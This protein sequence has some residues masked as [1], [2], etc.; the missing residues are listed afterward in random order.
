MFWG[1]LSLSLQCNERFYELYNG[2]FTVKYFL[3]FRV[4][5][6]YLNLKFGTTE[7]PMC[8]HIRNSGN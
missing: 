3:E 5:I 8:E 2:V 1:G 4:R 7:S 6:K